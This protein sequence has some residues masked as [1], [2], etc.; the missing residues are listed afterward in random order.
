MCLCMFGINR[1][2][3]VE[4]WVSCMLIFRACNIS[5]LVLFVVGDAQVCIGS[6]PSHWAKL[7]ICCEGVWVC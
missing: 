1:V 6:L 5:S 3:L 4:P 2:V 7:R